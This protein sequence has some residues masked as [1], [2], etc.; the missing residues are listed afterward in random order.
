MRKIF[1]LYALLTTLLITACSNETDPRRY[2]GCVVVETSTTCLLG[3][4][5]LKL[6]PHLRDSIGY[7]YLWIQVPGYELKQLQVGDTIK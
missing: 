5:K 4:L 3:N 1:A 7:D 6:T 2:K